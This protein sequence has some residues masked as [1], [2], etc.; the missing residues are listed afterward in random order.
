MTVCAYVGL[1]EGT[2]HG[3]GKGA[4]AAQRTG[5]HSGFSNPHTRN[6]GTSKMY[7]PRI[8]FFVCVTLLL[9]HQHP[10]LSAALS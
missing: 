10:W 8:A 1:M 7:I 3:L 4:E 5:W 9:P 6:K 2:K